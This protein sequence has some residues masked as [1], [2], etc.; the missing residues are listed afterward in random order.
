MLPAAPHLHLHQHPHLP[1]SPPPTA[2][3]PRHPLLQAPKLETDPAQRP[4]D[5]L[6]HSTALE[7]Q[8][9]VRQL[10][11]ELELELVLALSLPSLLAPKMASSSP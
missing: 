3:A 2:P 7:P 8:P 1:P 5:P 11:L 6:P 4:A 9:V 10:T